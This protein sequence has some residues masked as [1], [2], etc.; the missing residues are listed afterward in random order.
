MKSIV[1]ILLALF[2]LLQ[3]ELWFAPDSL[4]TAYQLHKNIVAQ[5]TINKTLQERNAIFNADI[6]DLKNG[7]EAIEE[8]A[9]SDL[10]MIKKGEVFY[11]IVQP[12]E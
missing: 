8:R 12:T 2:A 1:V 11:Q 10:G 6:R 3:Y 4:S 7:N 9:R 5:I